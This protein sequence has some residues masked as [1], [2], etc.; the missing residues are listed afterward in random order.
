MGWS[1]EEYEAFRAEDGEEIYW[2]F[3][4][5]YVARQGDPALAQIFLDNGIPVDAPHQPHGGTALGSSSTA[6]LARFL[7]AHG[8]NPNAENWEE[9]TP[10]YHA[11]T[12]N[13]PERVS[14]LLEYGADPRLRTLQGTPLELAME[15]G[16]DAVIPLLQA[17]GARLTT[18]AEEAAE[19][20]YPSFAAAFTRNDDSRITYWTLQFPHTPYSLHESHYTNVALRVVKRAIAESPNAAA[21]VLALLSG[22]NWRAHIVGGT[23][24]LLGTI[25]DA[26]LA[27]LWQ[28]IDQGNHVAPQLVSIAALLD[29]AFE[30][31]ARSRIEIAAERGNVNLDPYRAVDLVALV[32]ECQALQDTASWLEPACRSAVFQRVFSVHPSHGDTFAGSWREEILRAIREGR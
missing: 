18:V 3:F 4:C 9:L 25:D 11:I 12:D 7:L 13:D 6:E 29:P 21:E 23:A 32:R 1:A 15:Y 30:A 5:Q 2:R 20:G 24:V 31:K 19:A 14:L 26:I 17:A 8:A 27:A 16:A 22:R 10:L 28:A